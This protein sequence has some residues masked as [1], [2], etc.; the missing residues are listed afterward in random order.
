MEQLKKW[1]EF[2]DK[3]INEELGEFGSVNIHIDGNGFI[4]NAIINEI[5]KILIKYQGER[6]L[7]VDDEEINPYK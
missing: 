1:D 7:F 5:K 2:F 3:K 6:H 4:K